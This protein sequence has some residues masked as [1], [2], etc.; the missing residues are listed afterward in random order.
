MLISDG[1][2]ANR[3]ISNNRLSTEFEVMTSKNDFA[4]IMGYFLLSIVPVELN[5]RS[6]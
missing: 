6:R 3:S 4:E 5:C 2:I 1:H